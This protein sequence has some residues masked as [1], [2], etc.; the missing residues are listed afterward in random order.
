M[1]SP[2]PFPLSL[3]LCVPDF[4]Q[5]KQQQYATY[6]TGIKSEAAWSPDAS[7]EGET[8]ELQQGKSQQQPRAAEA[9]SF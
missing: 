9:S 7:E 6:N 2:F 8:T 4:K 3:C 1:P 5:K